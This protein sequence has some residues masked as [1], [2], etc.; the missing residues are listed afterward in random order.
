[1]L[2]RSVTPPTRM[3]QQ[4]QDRRGTVHLLRGDHVTEVPCAFFA[5]PCWG[6]MGQK[7]PRPEAGEILSD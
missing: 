3:N 6:N 2:Y 4:S 1:M 7:N 5:T